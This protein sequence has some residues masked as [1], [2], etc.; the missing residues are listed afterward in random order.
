MTDR[1]FRMA[2]AALGLTPSGTARLLR[3]DVRR[4]QRWEGGE[5]AVPGTVAA[6]LRLLLALGLSG[7]EAMRLTGPAAE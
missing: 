1:E 5:T 3:V 4:V 6:F 2:R 7:E